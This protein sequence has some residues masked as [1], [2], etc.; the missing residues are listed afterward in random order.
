[1]CVGPSGANVAKDDDDDSLREGERDP[2]IIWAALRGAA[3]TLTAATLAAAAVAAMWL[4]A[5]WTTINWTGIGGGTRVSL[6][7]VDGRQE[8]C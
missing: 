1:M 4:W 8:P 6:Q 7:V 3:A 5:A 2:R